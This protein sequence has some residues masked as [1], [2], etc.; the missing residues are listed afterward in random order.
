MPD[1]ETHPIG[2]QHK[3][4]L[5]EEVYEAAEQYRELDLMTGV[6]IKRDTRRKAEEHLD[7]AILDYWEYENEG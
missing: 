5:L 2:T 6:P 4:D 3:L 7:K 1:F